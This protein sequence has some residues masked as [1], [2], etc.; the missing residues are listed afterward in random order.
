MITQQD[1]SSLYLSAGDSVPPCVGEPGAVW[2]GCWQEA[3]APPFPP[4]R[5]RTGRLER[6]YTP[7]ASR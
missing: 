5:R 6:A 2:V 3:R 1:Q 7:N 4:G